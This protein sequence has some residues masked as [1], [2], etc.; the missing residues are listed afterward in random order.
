LGG[1]LAIF[2]FVPFIFLTNIN[3]MLF[4]DKWAVVRGFWDA[5]FL[6]S[7]FT[8]YFH[9]IIAT[10]AITA[11]FLVGY[12]GRKK[13]KFEEKFKTIDKKELQRQLYKI[14]LY[15]NLAQFVVG[16]L[17]LFALPTIGLKTD[18]LIAIILGAVIAIIP[19]YYMWKET[20]AKAENL[21]NYLGLIVVLLSITV[22]LMGTGRHF[23]RANA[24]QKYQ[25]E[26]QK[27]SDKYL[28]ELKVAQH[29]AKLKA[30][31]DA[32]KGISGKALFDSKCVMCHAANQNLVGPSVTEIVG[33]Y[34]GKNQE[35]K[36]W[37]NEPGKKR[38]N[39][40]QMPAFKGQIT[41]NEMEAL[42]K[43]IMGE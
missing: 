26:M 24:V 12:I 19:T 9:F 1:A 3:L 40:S 15:A 27:N 31:A 10:L 11:L 13:Y 2:L 35:M 34:K 22:L 38:A 33:I 14:A 42:V 4:P 5:L 39:S 16:T 28:A 25:V 43:Y 23:Y 20:K 8:R 30:E 36:N 32:K 17:N 41:D 18:T 7:V 6:P 21:G 37:I 29:E